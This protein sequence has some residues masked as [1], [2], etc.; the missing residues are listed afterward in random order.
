MLQEH[1]YID[2]R[3]GAAVQML[4]ACKLMPQHEPCL[5]ASVV[6][7]ATRLYAPLERTTG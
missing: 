5:Q 6:L 3:A 1:F 7:P 4:S 2:A